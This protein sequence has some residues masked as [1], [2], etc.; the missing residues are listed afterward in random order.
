MQQMVSMVCPIESPILIVLIC[1]LGLLMF[2]NGQVF[3]NDADANEH[4]RRHLIVCKH[5]ILLLF[6]YLTCC[7]PS[8]L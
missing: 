1:C 6:L 3:E 2:G 8:T 5:S 7:R 4:L